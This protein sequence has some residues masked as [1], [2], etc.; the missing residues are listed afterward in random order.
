M[1]TLTEAKE[2]VEKQQQV[3]YI[4]YS[5]F[6]PVE[7]LEFCEKGTVPERFKKEEN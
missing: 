3:K 2:A 7:R 5:Q 6:T 4:P 1:S